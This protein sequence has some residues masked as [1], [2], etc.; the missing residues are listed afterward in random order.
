MAIETASSPV[1]Q[2]GI[3]MR[4]G[5]LCFLFLNRLGK[6]FSVRAYTLWLPEKIGHRDQ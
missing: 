3:Q 5:S 1:A 2:P 6:I 4:M